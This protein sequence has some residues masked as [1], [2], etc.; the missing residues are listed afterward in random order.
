[1]RRGGCLSGFAIK[2]KAI[3]LYKTLY[4]KTNESLCEFKG[5]TGWFINFCNRKDLVL[6]RIT[7]KGRELPKNT[8][9]IIRQFFEE[10]QN[11]IIKPNL[12]N[13]FIINMDETSIYLDF[14][15]NYTYDSRGCKRVPARTTGSERTRLSA[16]LSATASGISNLY[17]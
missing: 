1:M 10:C 3:E 2:Q 12:T 8:L 17:S 9:T 5:S 14:P 13:E 7:T 16:A 11:I 4:E 15:T 6:R